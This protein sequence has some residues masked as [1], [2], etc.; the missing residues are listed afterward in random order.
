MI[1]VYNFYLISLQ[2]RNIVE[3]SHGISMLLFHDQQTGL[4]NLYH[5]AMSRQ[6]MG[7]TPDIKALAFPP[8]TQVDARL[9]HSGRKFYKIVGC[10][11]LFMEK[12]QTV[13]R[14]IRWDKSQ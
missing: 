3:F 2:H 5:H 1:V 10:E 8:N 14:T 6:F 11:A 4:H 7:G 9:H 13:A 12:H